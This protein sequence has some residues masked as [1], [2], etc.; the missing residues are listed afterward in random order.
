MAIWARS[1]EAL[2]NAMASFKDDKMDVVIFGHS[3]QA[4]KE[5]IGCNV[6]F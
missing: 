5:Q 4:F 1:R 2:K 6:V 3:H